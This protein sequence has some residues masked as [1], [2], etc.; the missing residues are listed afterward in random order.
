[1]DTVQSNLQSPPREPASSD[2]V[3]AEAPDSPPEFHNMTAHHF[4]NPAN[5]SSTVAPHLQG[6]NGGSGSV[7]APKLAQGAPGA[8][9][10]SKKFIDEYQRTELLLTDLNWDPG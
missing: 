10:N 1:M 8:T 6:N 7:G 9:W 2:Q 4:Q 5:S 3:M